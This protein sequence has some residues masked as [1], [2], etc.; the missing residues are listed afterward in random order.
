VPKLSQTQKMFWTHPMELKCDVGYL[1][2]CFDAF[3][4]SVGVYAW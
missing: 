1:E 3:G 4:E 2:S